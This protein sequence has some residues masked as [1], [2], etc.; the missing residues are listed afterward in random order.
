MDVG[1]FG[2]TYLFEV[3]QAYDEDAL[4]LELLR[5]PSFPSLGYMVENGGTTLWEGWDGDEHTVG[6][7]GT[8]RNHIMF[9]GGVNRFLGAAVAGLGVDAAPGATPGASTAGGGLGGAG[10]AGKSSS[11]AGGGGW[12][13]LAVR[14]APAA[15]RTLFRAAAARRTPAGRAA[16]EW[17]R[18]TAAARRAALAA[19]AAAPPAVELTLTVPAFSTADVALPLLDALRAAS[20][21]ASASASGAAVVVRVGACQVRCTATALRASSSEFAFA[22]EASGECGMLAAPVCRAR[23]D[24]EHVLDVQVVLPGSY[25]FAVMGN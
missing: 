15:M 11:A 20:A 23:R 18:P 10:A 19:G 12:R 21:G 24:G 1:I 3:L 17:T 2:T 14:P 8:S 16:V 6:T 13:R 22:T 4:G 5:E 7:L 9:G 25:H